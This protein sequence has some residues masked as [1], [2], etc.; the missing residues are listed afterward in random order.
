MSHHLLALVGTRATHDLKVYNA[1][2]GHGHQFEVKCMDQALNLKL[3]LPLN[4][5]WVDCLECD[6]SLPEVC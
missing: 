4:L 2:I 6:W 5:K 3:V 1:N